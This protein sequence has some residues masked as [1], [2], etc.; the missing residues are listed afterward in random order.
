MENAGGGKEKNKAAV[1]S[2][3]DQ[4]HT[5]TLAPQYNCSPPTQSPYPPHV[6]FKTFIWLSAYQ[7]SFCSKQDA[8]SFDILQS[9]LHNLAL[10][11]SSLTFAIH[12]LLLL[13]LNL[14]PQ[15]PN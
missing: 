6:L 3:K 11:F 8:F 14:D 9:S 5:H 13:L 7:P 15:L 2:L 12:F 4:S 1:V 10:L